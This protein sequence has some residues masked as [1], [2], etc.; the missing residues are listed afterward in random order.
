VFSKRQTSSVSA[1]TRQ[2]QTPL[3]FVGGIETKT[4]IDYGRGGVVGKIERFQG[5][6]SLSQY[7][8]A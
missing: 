1:Y 7:Q 8:N 6:A 4:E 3:V 2:H 5:D